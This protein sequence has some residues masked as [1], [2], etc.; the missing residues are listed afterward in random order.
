M[1]EWYPNNKTII[2]EHTQVDKTLFRNEQSIIGF[3]IYTINLL[4]VFG[5]HAEFSYGSRKHFNN[6]FF[7][8]Y[9]S[10]VRTFASQ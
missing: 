6:V 7:F 5:G 9:G 8:K 4:S 3:V 1:N 10:T 2:Y